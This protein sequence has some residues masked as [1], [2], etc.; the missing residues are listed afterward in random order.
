MSKD[1]RS[2]CKLGMGLFTSALTWMSDSLIPGVLEKKCLKCLN[3]YFFNLETHQIAGVLKRWTSMLSCIFTELELACLMNSFWW[4]V[5]RNYPLTVLAHCPKWKKQLLKKNGQDNGLLPWRGDFC[6]FV[7][8]KNCTI[9]GK[10]KKKHLK[11]LIWIHTREHKVQREATGSVQ[12]REW[13]RQC[14]F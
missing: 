13:T 8:T 6:L 12:N 9:G 5:K 3:L 7:I 2:R 14:S 1:L 11:A 4:K 10:K